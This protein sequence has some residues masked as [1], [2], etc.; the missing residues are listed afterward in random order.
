MPLAGCTSSISSYKACEVVSEEKQQSVIG[1]CFQ[2]Q[3]CKKGSFA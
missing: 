3:N 1:E 2:C